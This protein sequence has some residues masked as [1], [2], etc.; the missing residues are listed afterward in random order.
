MKYDD[1][2]CFVVN[3]QSIATCERNNY[4]PV[5]GVINMNNVIYSTAGNKI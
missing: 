3:K 2:S 4:I 5:F 1:R